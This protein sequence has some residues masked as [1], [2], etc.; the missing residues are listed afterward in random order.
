MFTPRLQG[1]IRADYIKNDKNGGGLYGY[2]GYS[3]TDENGAVVYGNDGRNGLGP[4]LSGDVNKGANR[5][6][7]TL[8]AKYAYDPATT[9][10]LEFRLDGAN[11]AVFEDVKSGAFK[12][13][14][15]MLAGSVVV[16]F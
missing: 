15:Q 14:N 8:G 6:A 10:K 1:L 7:V 13:N 5:Y 2:N 11:L 3:S 4:D 12:K 9:M 16:A